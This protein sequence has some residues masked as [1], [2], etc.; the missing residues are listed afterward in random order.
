MLELALTWQAHFWKQ[1]CSASSDRVSTAALW[2]MVE[3]SVYLNVPPGR[4]LDL[5]GAETVEIAS[6]QHDYTRVTV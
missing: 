4:T 2:N 1:K 3:I 5:V 6:A